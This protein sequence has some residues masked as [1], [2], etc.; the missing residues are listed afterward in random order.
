MTIDPVTVREFL[1]EWRKGLETS[2]ANH[3]HE[4]LD[5]LEETLFGPTLPTLAD[6]TPEEREACRWMQADVK[7]ANG[8]S[9]TCVI[10]D[11][12]TPGAKVRVWAPHGGSDDVQEGRVTPLPDLPKLEWPGSH[13]DAI[14]AE[15]VEDVQA[16]R[17]TN[18]EPTL[19]RPE[20]VPEGE[21]WLV[22]FD[23]KRWVGVHADILDRPW[24]ITRMD[25]LDYQNVADSEIT[26]ISRLVPQYKENA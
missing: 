17:V 20:D 23:G 3:S 1:T 4:I 2:G 14:T 9:V 19:P 18:F 25:G 15:S 13:A 10:A 22:E 5:D 16:G 12:R 21:P 11:P 26:L 8:G 24:S 7:L 6:M